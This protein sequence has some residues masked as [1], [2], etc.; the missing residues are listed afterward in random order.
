MNHFGTFTLAMVIGTLFGGTVIY[1]SDR[2][3]MFHDTLP[4]AALH[5]APEAGANLVVVP[6]VPPAE[7]DVQVKKKLPCSAR[8]H[9]GY[10]VAEVIKECNKPWRIQTIVT[11][12]SNGESKSVTMVYDDYGNDNVYLLN[13]IVVTLQYNENFP[14]NNNP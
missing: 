6:K 14:Y 1:L 4:D 13:D 10:T 9:V 2:A 3:P 11:K 5:A 8:V 7:I 12:D